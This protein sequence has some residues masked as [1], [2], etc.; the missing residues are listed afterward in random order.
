M[1]PPASFFLLFVASSNMNKPFKLTDIFL[2][3][4]FTIFFISLGVVLVLNFR[5]LYYFDIDALG[6]SQSSGL[7]KEIIIENYNALMEYCS[8]FFHGELSF[9]T[10]GASTNGLIHFAEVKRIFNLFY[11]LLPITFLFLAGTIVYKKKKKDS[12]YLLVSSITTIVLP[13]IVGIASILNF[14]KTFV[15][16]H[17]LVFRNDYWIFD[18]STDP[19]ITL[20][21]EEFFLHCA[22]FIVIVVLIGS[23]I[24]FGTFR[25]L[26]KK[27]KNQ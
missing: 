24:L 2:G 21:P 18:A 12:S 3:I 19:I 26:K 8:P 16:F 20:L 22:L 6:I 15:L 7:A 5:F 27:T 9:P 14:D 1:P 10:L 23:V 17:E 13:L 25:L 4:I 11:L